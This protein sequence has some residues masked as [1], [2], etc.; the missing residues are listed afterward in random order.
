[1]VAAAGN[2]VEA[3]HRIAVGGYLLPADLPPGS[4]TWLEPADLERL[5]PPAT[6]MAD[7]PEAIQAVTPD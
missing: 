2:R 4:W 6:H 3:L 7:S 5:D 1:M